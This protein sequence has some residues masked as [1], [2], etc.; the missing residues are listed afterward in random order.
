MT[1]VNPGGGG[2]VV[3]PLT[4][5]TAG[6]TNP[7]IIV[8]INSAD[9]NPA[10]T[11]RGDGMLQWGAGGA[12]ALDGSL[13]RGA[14]PNIGVT[15]LIVQGPGGAGNYGFGQVGRSDFH[16]TGADFPTMTVESS[17]TPAF[18]ALDSGGFI[19]TATAGIGYM[20]REGS[21]AKQ[22]VSAAM[23]AGAVT[24]ANTS[25]TANSRIFVTRAPG[26]TNP[27]AVYVSAQTAG[28]SFVITSTNAADTGTAYYVI[29]EP[30][31]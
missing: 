12:S 14:V 4:L 19:S 16:Y 6:A 31:A 29:F 5:A 3:A 13:S 25:V 10:F 21:N 26:G 27:G 30:T 23:T 15:G 8:K 24:V 17:G 18:G 9:A 28:T 2:G 11:I 20:V 22:G 1:V 7:A